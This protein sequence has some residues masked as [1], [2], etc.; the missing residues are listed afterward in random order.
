MSSSV[1]SRKRAS[2]P[3]ADGPREL[4]QGRGGLVLVTAGLLAA[5]AMHVVAGRETKG[6]LALLLLGLLLAAGV[7]VGAAMGVVGGYGVFVIQGANG[8]LAAF[9]R[10]PYDTAASWS[11][12]VLPMF[13]LMGMLLWRS[14]ATDRLYRGARSWLG[15]LP[16]GLAVT[17][18]TAGAVLGAA[19]G[20]T[21]GIAYALGRI[22]IPSMLTAGYS[23]RLAVGSVL[24]AGSG[25][26]LIPPSVL[27]VVYA[28]VASTPVGDQ[29]LAGLVPGV[30]LVSGYSIPIII[31]GM[32]HR[33]GNLFSWRQ[34]LQALPQMWA[35]PTLIGAIIGGLYSGVFTATEAGA[36]G[37]FLSL[38]LTVVYRRA[39]AVQAIRLAVHE[40][41]TSVG[42]V[43]FLLLGAAVFG[44]F[45]GISGLSRGLAEF[46]V[47]QD[48]TRVQFLV[49]LV[50]TYLILG[51]FLDPLALIILTV[52]VLMP[53]FPA[54]NIDVVWFGVF[55]VLMAEV[56]NV[57]P[58]IGMLLY[59]V[60]AIA[61]DPEV[62]LGQEIALGDVMWAA[63]TMLPVAVLVAAM[64]IAFPN[65][66]R[67]L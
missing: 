37:A 59:V 53:L 41:V 57:T 67:L 25:G 5:V 62:N 22:G 26:Q 36:V 21:L 29:L 6:L 48:L 12:S 44:R 63:L 51:M 56:S 4:G 20:S 45:V 60:H 55:V 64:L 7:H 50:L 66:V 65:V 43:L 23:K 30:I 14:G 9:T 19:S 13:I 47:A 46:I 17:T 34:R 1:G 15:W 3:S 42:A 61:Q 38:I 31:M 27:L 39:G 40:S 16:G 33:E 2:S 35:V 11:L 32:K 28:G 52:P 49:Y 24:M 8:L 10:L 58:P 54:L 18:N